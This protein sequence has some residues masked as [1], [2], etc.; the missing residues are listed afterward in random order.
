MKGSPNQA[1]RIVDSEGNEQSVKIN[2]GKTYLGIVSTGDDTAGQ[3]GYYSS[4]SAS[5]TSVPEAD[6]TATDYVDTDQ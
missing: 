6:S 2:P 1:L 3:F 5:S 4:E